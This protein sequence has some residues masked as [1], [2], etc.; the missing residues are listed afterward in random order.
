VPHVRSIVYT[1][2]DVERKPADRYARV[3]LE[4]AVLIVGHGIKG[5]V[6][7]NGGRQLNVLLDEDVEQLR[8]EGFRTGPGEL[9]EQ[10]VLAGLGPGVLAVGVRVRLGAD[11]VIEITQA[12]KGCGR[13]AAVQGRP[14]DAADGRIGFLA[15]VL[16]GGTVAV[17][18]EVSVELAGEPAGRLAAVK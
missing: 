1:P 16:H 18:D 11:A 14:G 17:G 10:L 3:A 8:A 9:G 7:G 15:R 13:F 4:R 5:D 2:A 12:R 6:K